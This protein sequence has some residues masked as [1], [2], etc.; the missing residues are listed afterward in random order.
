MDDIQNGL[1]EDFGLGYLKFGHSELLGRVAGSNSKRTRK[2]PA[3]N[4]LWVSDSH[5]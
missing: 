4:H 3:Q 5:A 2:S 1:I